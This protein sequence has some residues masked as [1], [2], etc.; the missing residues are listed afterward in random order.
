MWNLFWCMVL[1]GLLAIL[2]TTLYA[3]SLMQQIYLDRCRRDLED[4]AFLLQKEALEASRTGEIETG[5][6][7]CKSHTG[8]SAA[9]LTLIRADGVVLGDSEE[10]PSRME[11]HADRPEIKDA[12]Q[13]RTGTSVRLSPTLHVDMLYVAIPLQ[14]LGKIVGVLRVAIPLQ[15]IQDA[16]VA[17][18]FKALAG[19]IG[20]A[21]LVGLISWLLSLKIT[22][23]LVELRAAADRISAGDLAC[24]CKV[25]DTDEFAAMAESL[26]RMG[27]QLDDRI[28]T[29]LRQ[30]NELEAVLSSMVEG[31]LVIDRE[32]RL[33]RI[34]RAAADFLG[35]MSDESIGRSIQEVV[36][37][38][39]LQRFLARTR[40]VQEPTEDQVVLRD[41]GERHLQVHGT[42]LRD[43]ENHLMG[44]LVVLNDVTR[45]R[46][47]EGVRRDFVANVSHELK[48]PITSI[49]GFV[50]T[51]LDGAL[52]DPKEAENFLQIVARQ[53]D[54]L[55]AII[56]DL[57]TLSKIEQGEEQESIV[58]EEASVRD[59]VKSAIQACDLKAGAKDIR[60]DLHADEHLRASINAPLL[61]QAL[62]NLIDNAIKY[63]EPGGMIKIET[64]RAHNEIAL[65]VRDFGCGIEKE[66]LSRIF[67]RFYRVDKARS[68]KLGGT[69]LGLAIVKHIA[70]AHKGRVGVESVPGKGSTFTIYI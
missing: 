62:V 22:R 2:V 31:V 32:E 3:S 4:R 69:G 39:D 70:Q 18:Y 35:I 1:V 61:E 8:P 58:L 15:M 10:S 21:C 67:E 60:I 7:F 48:T 43:S 59:V 29:L 25:S 68:R 42:V 66:H 30:R 51:L 40:S 53:A 12:M 55:N 28:R 56:E 16:M 20:V 23:P 50:E 46:R 34:N 11:N 36:R 6:H 54:R 45:M 37:N 47:L 63:S 41:E 27:E 26:N 9:R 24:R 19:G 52:H 49:K 64:Q 5:D 57:L 14:D 65:S 38:A 13:G 33:V 17:F 44:V